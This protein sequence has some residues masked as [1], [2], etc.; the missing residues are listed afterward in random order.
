MSAPDDQK[1]QVHR[2]RMW[3]LAAMAVGIGGIIAWSLL[4][5]PAAKG[6]ASDAY[7][8][9][10]DVMN[11]EAVN[12][13]FGDPG[14]QTFAGTDGS[15]TISGT[16]IGALGDPVTYTCQAERVGTGTYRVTWE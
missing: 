11:R 4:F 13:T 2:V 14:D 6:D 1:A 9:C 12:A 16:F 15:W 7:Y 3:I 10:V 5:N 8:A